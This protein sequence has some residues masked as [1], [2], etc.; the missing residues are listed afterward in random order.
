[1]GFLSKLNPN[2]WFSSAISGGASLIGNIVGNKQQNA[3]IDKQIAFQREE[4]EKARAFNKAMAEQANQWSIDQWNRENQYNS[5]EAMRQRLRDAGV[6]ADLFYGGNAQNTASASPSV[7]PV[8]PATPTDVSAIGQKATVGDITNNVVSQS[9]AAAQIRK[10]EADKGKTKQETENLKIEGKILSADALT[11]AAQNEQALEIGRSTIYVNHSIAKLNQKEAELASAR[12]TEAAANADLLYEKANEVKAN[13]RNINANTAATRFGMMMRTKEFRQ[14]VRE[15]QEQV[16]VND[17]SIRLSYE[18]A[19]TYLA[20][21]SATVLNINADTTLKSAGVKTQYTSRQ[22]MRARTEMYGKLD[23]LINIQGDQAAFNLDSDKKYKDLE[24]GV[25]L[26]TGIIDSVSGVI[27]SAGSFIS[28][29]G[30]GLPKPVGI[31][32]LRK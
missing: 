4:N 16:R 14:R 28:G 5:P 23:R 22:E 19:A 24:R 11:R 2:S 27:G 3:N 20:T 10:L 26:V 1:M 15:F 9:L 31:R 32:G 13:I 12:I 8:A 25:S 29:T 6:N 30:I 18:Q 17:S 7:T 21:R